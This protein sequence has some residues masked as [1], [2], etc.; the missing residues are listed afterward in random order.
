MWL[1]VLLTSK[2]LGDMGDFLKCYESPQIQLVAA[3]FCE[4][5]FLN[6]GSDYFKSQENESAV[7]QNIGWML[8]LLKSKQIN[9]ELADQVR[10][11]SNW[12]F[13]WHRS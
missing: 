5:L 2:I 6:V 3:R 4:L 8:S 13:F 7:R 11:A 9:A 1:S 12:D 10:F